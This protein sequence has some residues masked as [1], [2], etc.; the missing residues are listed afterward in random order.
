MYPR[1]VEDVLYAHPAVLEAAVIG[2]PDPRW[3]ERVHAVVVLRP[4]PAAE[5]TPV[6][7]P[8]DRAAGPL[9]DDLIAHCRA[10]LTK[11]KCPTS[12]AFVD[13]LP[14][15]ATGKVLKKE[16]RAAAGGQADTAAAGGQADTAAAGEVG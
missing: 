3:G 8:G 6:G 10:S 11:Y 1:E 12:V 15:N 9:V 5:G 7:Q 2:L 13:V 14:K 16:L 4:G